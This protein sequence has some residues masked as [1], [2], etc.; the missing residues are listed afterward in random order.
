MTSTATKVAGIFTV[1]LAV[2]AG[3]LILGPLGLIGAPLLTIALLHCMSGPR[4]TT[5]SSS[6]CH[7]FSNSTG[8]SSSGYHSYIPS[9]PQPAPRS[10]W[11]F[12]NTTPITPR[13]VHRAGGPLPPSTSYAAEPRRPAQPM[14]F[15]PMS[16]PA[17][18]HFERTHITRPEDERP[19]P[20]AAYATGT[21]FNRGHFPFG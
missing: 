19:N 13:P 4:T 9:T 17:G 8:Y 20:P 18:S 5:Y 16:T 10:W 2:L 11:N 15:G 14:Q 3:G 7:S 1:I 6:N 21:H 12:W